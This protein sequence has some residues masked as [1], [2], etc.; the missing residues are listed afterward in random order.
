MKTPAETAAVGNEFSHQVALFQWCNMVAAFGVA[1]ANCSKSYTE[2]G[3]AQKWALYHKDQIYELSWLY[4]VKNA[5]GRNNAIAGARNAAEGVKAGVPDLCLPVPI[6]AP[7]TVLG[8]KSYHGL[9]IELKRIEIRSP[10]SG[11]I[12]VAKG[13]TSDAQDKWCE[14][15][16]NSGYAVAVCYGW[17]A[18]RDVLLQYLNGEFR[19]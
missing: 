2:R 17:E 1:A 13:K 11:N 10:K 4:A 16:R 5:V 19:G 14:F 3:E 6:K 12:C 7:C 8:G 15:L 18:A 9:Y